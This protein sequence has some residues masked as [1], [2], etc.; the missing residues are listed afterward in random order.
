M[1]IFYVHN[2][3]RNTHV[4]MW[5][6]KRGFA[7]PRRFTSSLLYIKDSPAGRSSLPFARAVCET[8]AVMVYCYRNED[9]GIHR[10]N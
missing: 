3:I 8:R 6:S 9:V 7:R 4:P 1:L 5:C 2:F 10:Q